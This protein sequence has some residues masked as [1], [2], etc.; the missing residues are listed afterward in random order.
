VSENV[1]ERRRAERVALKLRGR[2]M[3]SDGGECHCQT[4]DVSVVGIALKG[5]IAPDLGELIIVYLDELGRV[6]GRVVRRGEGWFAID[7]RTSQVRIKR[8]EQKIAAL[9]G[10]TPVAA[11][12]MPTPEQ[13]R[14]ALLRTDFG[15]EFTVQVT[16]ETPTSARVLTHLKLLPGTRVTIDGL[17]GVVGLGSQN[18]FL[19]ELGK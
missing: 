3:L 7:A 2:Y 11:A 5:Y 17:R 10:K 14:S 4:I 18:C 13:Y 8:I 1:A 9:S 15:L 6:E 19:V 12:M 16:D